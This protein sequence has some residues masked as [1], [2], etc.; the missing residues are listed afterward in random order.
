MQVIDLD[1][2]AQAPRSRTSYRGIAATL[3]VGALLGASATYGWHE[4]HR[5]DQPI[6]VFVFAEAT[7]PQ[8][9]PT[10]TSSVIRDG[11][12]TTVTLTRR[13]TLVNAGPLPVTI[14][15]VSGSRPG[16]TVKSPGAQVDPGETVQTRAD[17]LVDCARGLP[18]GRLVVTLHVRTSD[19]DDQ[20]TEPKE[21]FD[22][23]PWTEQAEL[24]CTRPTLAGSVLERES[25]PAGVQQSQHPRTPAG[26]P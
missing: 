2:P 13:V 5:R 19:D 8:A 23:S 6:S 10:D 3:A 11:R 26:R 21:G 4:R 22:G 1:R 16:V 17:V 14:S 12:V 18:L 9:D 15:D 7:G 24:A 20:R 25:H